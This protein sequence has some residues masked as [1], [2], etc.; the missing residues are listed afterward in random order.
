MKKL[1][2]IFLMFVNISIV[3][4]IKNNGSI[5][6]GWINGRETIHQNELYNARFIYPDASFYGNI[7]L[8]FSYK[9]I[10]FTQSINN[11]FCY[12]QGKSFSPID[13]EF[14]SVL[15]FTYKRFSI[16][17]QHSCLHPIINQVSD[18]E[19]LWRRGNEDRIYLKFKW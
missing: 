13:V 18:V 16:G 3:G 11:V 4:Q 9:F 17:Y 5:E 12:K 6:I 1:A 8:D 19:N 2:I 7:N 10:N 14:I 15:G